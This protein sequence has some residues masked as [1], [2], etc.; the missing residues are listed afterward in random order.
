M[1]VT[2]QVEQWSAALPQL[3]PLFSLLWADVA[4]DK[5]RFVAKCDESKYKILEDAGALHLCTMRNDGELVG[6]YAALIL[7]N[8]H[9]F[10]QGLMVYTDMYYLL[11]EYRRGN[12]GLRFFAFCEQE[13]RKRGAVKAYS[14]H[15]LHRDRSK[16][17]KTLGW[18]PTD[19][20]YSK[21]L[22]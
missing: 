20:I 19:M 1:K 6:Y 5:D 16:M 18:K 4:V 15:K 11:K 12:L 7:P 3:R 13:W 22:D 14:S 10:G 2:F 21:V 8:P 17:F 9:Y